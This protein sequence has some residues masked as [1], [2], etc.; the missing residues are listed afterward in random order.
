MFLKIQDNKREAKKNFV[1][2]I[3]DFDSYTQTSDQ[4][5]RNNLENQLKVM[6]NKLDQRSKQ[7]YYVK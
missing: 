6:K 7:S 2:M 5:V 1:K 4:V 3:Q